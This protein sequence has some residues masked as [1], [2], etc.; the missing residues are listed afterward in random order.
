MATLSRRR[1]TYDDHPTPA[2][3]GQPA[4]RQNHSRRSPRADQASPS[5]ERGRVHQSPLYGRESEYADTGASLPVCLG[6]ARIG[7][8]DADG[9]GPTSKHEMETYD[10]YSTLA[11]KFESVIALWLGPW[12]YPFTAPVG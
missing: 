6:H 8:Y 5:S 12:W 11:G 9:Y 7:K 4:L 2:K 1:T 3:A 10:V